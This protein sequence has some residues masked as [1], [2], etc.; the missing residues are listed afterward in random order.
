MGPEAGTEVGLEVGTD[1]G[2][3]VGAG[4]GLAVGDDEGGQ[5]GT[6]F[7]RT[8]SKQN[9]GVKHVHVDFGLEVG[10]GRGGTVKVGTGFG[11]TTGGIEIGVDVGLGAPVG[12]DDRHCRTFSSSVS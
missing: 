3:V 2:L 12:L 5:L 4:V 1:V 8:K 10:R 6:P 9:L 11:V 7:R